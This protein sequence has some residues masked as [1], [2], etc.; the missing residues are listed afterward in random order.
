MEIFCP[1]FLIP[2][3]HL[4]YLC[5]TEKP[6]WL[7]WSD[8]KRSCLCFAQNSPI[9]SHLRIKGKGPKRPSKSYKM[10]PPLSPPLWSF[11]LITLILTYFILWQAKHI[12]PQGT[13]GLLFPLNK[14]LFH[15][16]S[17]QLNPS[18]FLVFIQILS[19]SQD[20]LL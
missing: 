10:W 19:L 6:R 8:R 17:S 1:V 18:P 7:H 12:P 15:Q 4:F 20:G 11:F 9:I 3:L 13:L 14:T 5:L 16:I 2:P